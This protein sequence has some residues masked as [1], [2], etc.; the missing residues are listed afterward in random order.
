MLTSGRWLTPMP[1]RNRPG[2]ASPSVASPAAMAVASRDQMLAIPA[3]IASRSVAA[4]RTA[5]QANGSLLPRPS[6]T[7]AEP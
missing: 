6:L 1:I 5:A 2:K 3:P 7:H 4:S